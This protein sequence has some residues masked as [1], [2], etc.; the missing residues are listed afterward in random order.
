MGHKPVKRE[1][2]TMPGTRLSK[3]GKPDASKQV[4][5][6]SGTKLVFGEDENAI[7]LY[8]GMKDISRKLKEEDGSVVYYIMHDGKRLVSMPNSYALS[9]MTFQE[10]Q[11]YYIHVAGMVKMRS[12][13]NDM[14]DFEIIQ[15]GGENETVPCDADLVGAPEITLTLPRIAELNYNRMNYPL[16]KNVI[17]K[18]EKPS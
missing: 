10:N 2:E 17:P 15:L 1:A 3:W 8:V 16:R 13:M 7:L 6:P 14:K 18:T 4:H 9:E 12:D 5:L 11:F